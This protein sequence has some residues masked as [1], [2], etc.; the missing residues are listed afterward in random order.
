ML[1]MTIYET[2]RVLLS[3]VQ[4]IATLGAPFMILWLDR[5][6]RRDNRRE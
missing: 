4:I 3:V 1:G 5:K 6:I 2:L